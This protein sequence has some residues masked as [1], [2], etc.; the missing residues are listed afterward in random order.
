MIIVV[1]KLKPE[2]I[3]NPNRVVRK[4]VEQR[5][6]D[7]ERVVVTANLFVMKSV[8]DPANVIEIV[9]LKK[10]HRL[11]QGIATPRNR[12]DKK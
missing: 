11:R 5:V 9:A 1:N 6:V 2:W 7:V 12:W 10:E 4:S 3:Q 8:V